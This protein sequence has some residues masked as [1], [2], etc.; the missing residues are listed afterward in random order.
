MKFPSLLFQKNRKKLEAS[1]IREWNYVF[2]RHKPSTN[3]N[4]DE[5]LPDFATFKINE[6]QSCNW[7]NY[8]IPIWTRFN[9]KQDYC[10]DYAVAGFKVNTIRGLQVGSKF[11]NVE[12]S[13]I[14]TNYSHCEIR[15][16]EKLTKTEKREI[17]ASLHQNCKTFLKPNETKSNLEIF[18]C[19]ISMFARRF[20]S[21]NK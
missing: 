8:S 19:I 6:N 18:I 2:T 14:Q 15:T 5:N 3:W 12:H 13:P 17:R 4:H 16:S 11:F 9:D 10:S 1:R 20:L 21:K 7:C